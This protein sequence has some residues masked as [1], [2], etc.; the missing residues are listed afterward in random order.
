MG[1]GLEASHQHWTM[2]NSEMSIV[3]S[4]QSNSKQFSTE[5]SPF[6][7]LMNKW[8]QCKRKQS[9]AVLVL[10]SSNHIIVPV[11]IPECHI[12]QFHNLP[13]PQTLYDA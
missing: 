1:H 13:H 2:F 10:V 11:D 5:D 9:T 3:T 7:A 8:K 12:Y 4:T 6:F